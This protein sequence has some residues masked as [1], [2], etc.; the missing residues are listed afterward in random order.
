MKTFP[1]VCGARLFFD[2]VSCVQCRREVGW[3]PQ[4]RRMVSLQLSPDGT[5]RC[6]Q[7]QGHAPLL[8][9]ANYFR[10]S[11]CN[12]M[13]PFAPAEHPSGLCD[14][15][16]YNAVIPDLS[17]PGHRRRWAELEAAKRRLFYTLDLLKLPHGTQADGFPL[18]LS[19]AFMTHALPEQGYWRDAGD[20]R[21]YTGHRHGRI[22]I[23]VKEADAVERERVRADLNEPLRT[24]I[25]HFRHEIGHYY[26]ELL[27]PGRA[28]DGF[29]RLFGDPDDPPYAQALA[30]YYQIGPPVDWEQSFLS[31]YATMHPWEDFAECFAFY[32]TVVAVLDTAQH[33]GLI[34]CH[35]LGDDLDAMLRT[36][37][38]AGLAVNELNRERGL[39]DLVPEMVT[40]VIHEKLQFVHQL[41]GE[42]RD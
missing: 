21:I 1:C 25:G 41:I 34:P 23:N 2:S 42:A 26:W 20:R 38:Q 5:Y 39:K 16:R 33:W 31:V 17:V 37:N 30:S 27:V 3:C 40:A 24:L 15:C 29:R 6:L 19:F 18:P 28:E 4:C 36:F 32:L 22:T 8:K 35:T 14:C 10:E 9:C 13:V 11:V 12:R 7:D